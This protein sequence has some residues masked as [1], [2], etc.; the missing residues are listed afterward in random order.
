MSNVA[1]LKTLT[2]MSL[3][4]KGIK[5]QALFM[6][7]RVYADVFATDDQGSWPLFEEYTPRW[8][9][10]LS[11]LQQTLALVEEWEFSVT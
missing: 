4:S 2:N 8:Q 1:Q 7:E 6:Q 3:V 9:L 11:E 5:L 10:E